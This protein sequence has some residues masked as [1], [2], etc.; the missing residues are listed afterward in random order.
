MSNNTIGERIKFH[1]KRLGLTQDQL[2]QRLGVSAQAVSKWEHNLSCPDV[3]VLPEIADLFGITVD[4]L[5]GK[6][7]ATVHEAEVVNE[8]EKH[9]SGPSITWTWGLEAKKSSILFSL[10][11]ILFGALLLVNH[12]LQI[13][14]SWWTI[15]WTT[16]LIYFGVSGLFNGFSVFSLTLC[17]AGVYFLLDAYAL[18]S[19]NLTWGVVL[20]TVL[21]L[22]G[23][24]LLL[25]VF[26]GKKWRRHKSGKTTVHN[27]KK[28]R[29]D[30]TCTDGYMRCDVSFGSY[31]TVVTT[32]LLRGGEID[33][34]FGD[35]I[36]DFSAC[37][38]IAPDCTVNVDNSFGSLTLLVPKRFAVE[39]AEN[40]RFAAS[41]EIEGSPA[42]QPEGTLHLK[43][44]ND[45][46]TLSIRYTE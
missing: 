39:V 5:L 44:D 27:N 22:W 19:F 4:E 18:F 15:L 20:P 16:A 2:A 9:D 25:D 37:R 10:Y 42:A 28:L 24:S 40:E 6:S 8:K 41:A 32:D 13:D 7:T 23:L 34:S 30:Y 31:R 12:F 3:S 11:I 1:R 21:L 33:A 38:A 43:I 14:I 26:A 46:G 35:F 45:F 17:L 36:V 29:H